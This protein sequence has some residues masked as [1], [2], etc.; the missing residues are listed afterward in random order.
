[1]GENLSTFIEENKINEDELE[2]A[3]FERV[4][5]E[6]YFCLAKIIRVTSLVT[7]LSNRAQEVRDAIKSLFENPL[8][9]T[10]SL[11]AETNEEQLFTILKEE[12]NNISHGM[13]RVYQLIWLT[14]LSVFKIEEKD[15]SHNPWNLVIEAVHGETP[16]EEI[17]RTYLEND[18]LNALTKVAMEFVHGNKD[19]Q[20]IEES[21]SAIAKLFTSLH[22][23][24]WSD[25]TFDLFNRRLAE[26][27]EYISADNSGA[28]SDKPKIGV[29]FTGEKTIEFY[30]TE[31]SP[32]GKMVL[33]NL[34]HQL[35]ISGRSLSKNEKFNIVKAL[36]KELEGQ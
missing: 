6:W 27:S 25:E 21:S 9:L 10:V 20:N 8:S 15:A 31:L 32:L 30:K 12:V 3:K 34:L 2:N 16:L 23:F 36:F 33:Q 18:K 29:T 26:I 14:F 13:E 35:E 1:M 7:I 24:D 11:A 4:V 19:W 17:S 5:K 28:S 22:P